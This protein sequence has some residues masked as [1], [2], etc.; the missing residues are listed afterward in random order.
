EATRVARQPGDSRLARAH[1][2]GA[3]GLDLALDHAGRRAKAVRHLL[4][5][6]PR[7]RRRAADHSRERA[8][9]SGLDHAG[10]RAGAA[11]AGLPHPEKS[12]GDRR[13]HIHRRIDRLKARPRDQARAAGHDHRGRQAEIRA[14]GLELRVA[15]SEWK[16]VSQLATRNSQ[17]ATRNNMNIRSITAPNPGPLT[18]DG[19]RTYLIDDA[20][21]LAPG[22]ATESH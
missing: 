22:P 4:L 16:P 12:R 10:G 15:R 21:V 5:H 19:P 20:A 2:S 7:R 13:I 17:P 9:R 3:T 18:L 8:R 1:R 11:G 14:D 6:R